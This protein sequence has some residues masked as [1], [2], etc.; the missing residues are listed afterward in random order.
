MQYWHIFIPLCPVILNFY[1]SVMLGP[2]MICSYL[3]LSLNK[4][5]CAYKMLYYDI[6]LCWAFFVFQILHQNSLKWLWNPVIYPQARHKLVLF[7]KLP[8]WKLWGYHQMFERF[9]TSPNKNVYCIY[10]YLSL[11][12]LHFYKLTVLYGMC[13]S[14]QFPYFLLYKSHFCA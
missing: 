1:I 7:I 3:P 11:K 9:I 10:F 13:I 14:H 2:K 6:I 5:T 8:I 12:A 4:V